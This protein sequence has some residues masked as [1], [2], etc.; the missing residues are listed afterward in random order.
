MI[1][2]IFFSNT[3]TGTKNPQLQC[4]NYEPCLKTFA[5]KT[6]MINFDSI[7]LL[8]FV[9]SEYSIFITRS[10]R[11]SLENRWFKRKMDGYRVNHASLVGISISSEARCWSHKFKSSLFRLRLQIK[12]LIRNLGSEYEYS[13]SST[14]LSEKRKI[15]EVWHVNFIHNSSPQKNRKKH[16]SNYHKARTNDDTQ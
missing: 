13:F 16:L 10:N 3:S 8:A 12:G 4:W 6:D 7:Y 15:S 1:I 2:E 5:D 9:V 14:F 11:N